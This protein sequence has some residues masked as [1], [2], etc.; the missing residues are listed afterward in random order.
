MKIQAVEANVWWIALADEIRPRDG[1]A[2]HQM[3]AAVQKIF[4]FADVPSKLPPP[5]QGYDFREGSLKAGENDFIAINK[6]SVFNDGINIQV[7]TDTKKAEMALHAAFE[8]FY[9]L[10]LREPTTPPLHYYLSNIVADFDKSLDGFIDSPLLKLVAA[11]MPID[12]HAHL[13]SFR[14]NFDP[15]AVPERMGPINPTNFLIER[16]IGVPYDQNRYFCQ[17][18]TTTEKHVELLEKFEKSA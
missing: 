17:A 4:N 7:P 6:L 8:V 2:W 16:R 14:I 11:A 3:F 9:S 5:N 13:T 1:V 10:G 15:S 18:N 12:G